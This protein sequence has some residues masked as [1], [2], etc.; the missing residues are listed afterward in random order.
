MSMLPTRYN[1]DERLIIY[2]GMIR[3]LIGRGRWALVDLETGEG[4]GESDLHTLHMLHPS[5]ARQRFDLV[6][7]DA[8]LKWPEGLVEVAADAVIA[9]GAVIDTVWYARGDAFTI[10]FSRN[11]RP[12][13]GGWETE[14]CVECEKPID[15][16]TRDCPSCCRWCATE[17]EACACPWRA[18]VTVRVRIAVEGGPI[19]IKTVGQA[20]AAPSGQVVWG[21]EGIE[22][23]FTHMPSCTIEEEEDGRLVVYETRR[24]PVDSHGRPIGL[25]SGQ[26][27]TLSVST[28]PHHESAIDAPVAVEIQSSLDTFRSAVASP[29]GDAT[30][31]DRNSEVDSSKDS[32]GWFASEWR[33][34]T[35]ETKGIAA[36]KPVELLAVQKDDPEEDDRSD[37]VEVDYVVREGEKVVLKNIDGVWYVPTTGA[38]DTFEAM[39]PRALYEATAA[40][41]KALRAHSVKWSDFRAMEIE[42]DKALA[43]LAKA[44]GYTVVW[45]LTEIVLRQ[46]A[47][48]GE[49]AQATLTRIVRER[50]EDDRLR[51]KLEKDYHA[52]VAR[53]HTLQR[54]IGPIVDDPRLDLDD[55]TD[56]EKSETDNDEHLIDRVRTLRVLADESG[57]ARTSLANEVAAIRRASETAR[58]KAL[59]EAVAAQLQI[60]QLNERVAELDLDNAKLNVT[61]NRMMGR[62]WM[63]IKGSIPDADIEAFIVELRKATTGPIRPWM[64]RAAGPD[65][66]QRIIGSWVEGTKATFEADAARQGFVDLEWRPSQFG[67]ELWGRC[68]VVTIPLRAIG[69]VVAGLVVGDEHRHYENNAEKFGYTDLE[70]RPSTARA[71]FVELWGRPCV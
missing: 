13:D 42:R 41:L 3:A 21:R 56:E 25:M 27:F 43:E 17:I 28:T 12:A 10:D 26:E 38:C 49:E 50:V 19:L 30:E 45:G 23:S 37:E 60:R 35:L 1:T 71:G 15:A 4:I 40:E 8:P 6:H 31:P 5:E 7:V 69:P 62:P 36:L 16:E 58:I 54:E 2:D 57:R 18:R 39:T 34:P 9:D 33:R 24:W 29:V 55:D 51:P 46:V 53:L 11:Q 44:R 14:Y 47:L 65:G 66:M 68:A 67:E 59:G 70:W 61:I 64:I 32:R 52:V 63:E 20:M 22:R 48:E